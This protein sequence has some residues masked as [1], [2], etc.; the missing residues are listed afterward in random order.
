MNTK[1]FEPISNLEIGQIIEV[2]G[3]HIIAELDP[4]IQELARVFQG[5]TYQIGQFGSIIKIHRGRKV[6][7]AYVGRLRMKTEYEKEL[8]YSPSSLEDGRIIEADLFGEGEW[9]REEEKWS[10]KFERGVSNFP[11]PKQKIYLT[12]SFELKLIYSFGKESSILLGE[13]VGS[14]GTNC[15]A[16]INEML[17][18]H[19]AILGSTGSGKSATVAAILHSILNYGKENSL[20]SWKPQ[21]IILDPHNEYNKSFP[22]GKKFTTD[23]NSLSL[24]YWLL[25]LEEMNDLIIGK[26]EFVATSQ[27]NIIKNALLNSRIEV[28]VK[29]NLD[30]DKINVDSPIPFKWS[31]FIDEVNNQRPT[32]KDK[33]E[34]EPFNKIIEKLETL[35]RDARLNFLMD[36]WNS[37]TDILSDIIFQFINKEYSVSIIDLS[38]IPNEVAGVCSAVISRML[39]NFKVWET[40]EE[41]RKNPILI[42]CEEAHRYVPNKGEAQYHSA[43]NAVRRIAK[44]GRKY[45]IGLFLVSQRPS[46]IESTVLSQCNTWIILRLTNETDR[47]YVKNILPDSLSGLNKI[48]SGLRRR[49]AVFVGQA[50]VLPSRIQIRKLESTQLPESQDIK[51][52]VGW[53]TEPIDENQIKNISLRWR[54]Q[55]RTIIEDNSQNNA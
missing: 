5:E 46:E 31:K 28:T 49:E 26:T 33:K 4:A 30:K 53:Q 44:E 27:S 39:F 47:E 19:T 8:G 17:G 38:G 35:R 12:P 25:N 11:L 1:P 37:E 48:L 15:Y 41:R 42:V 51:F 34:Q 10:L 54:Y 55:N 7:Y 6:L 50:A 22:E 20:P 16:D 23:N 13:Y 18:K 32:G 29:L 43:Q 45:G 2:D 40:T 21:I 3:T 52:D 24:P 36:E 14:A 9:L